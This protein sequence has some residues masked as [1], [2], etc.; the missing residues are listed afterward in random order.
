MD[1]SNNNKKVTNQISTFVIFSSIDNFFKPSLYN[2]T[3]I[4]LLK[5]SLKLS[6]FNLR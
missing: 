4:V 6:K 3:I 2:Y 5:Y 1:I